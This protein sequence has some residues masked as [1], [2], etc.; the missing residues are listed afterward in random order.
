AEV[1]IV[2]ILILTDVFFDDPG[3][4][5]I[6]LCPRYI[7]FQVENNP[8]I[9]PVWQVIGRERFEIR[10]TPFVEPVACRIDVVS[11]CLFGIQYVRVSIITF[12]NRII[13]LL[14]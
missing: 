5:G 9:L 11:V 7:F 10:A 13:A 14:R 1:I 12:E 4:P 8:F 2:L 6:S 3:G